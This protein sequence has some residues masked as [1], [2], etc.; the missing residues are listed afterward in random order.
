[1]P[2][3][4]TPTEQQPFERR[5]VLDAPRRRVGGTFKGLTE[6]PRYQSLPWEKKKIALQRFSENNPSPLSAPLT[7]I[8]R[9]EH[10]SEDGTPPSREFHSKLLVARKDWLKRATEGNEGSGREADF[11]YNRALRIAQEDYQN[12]LDERQRHINMALQFESANE[13]TKLSPGNVFKDIVGAFNPFDN[14]EK[15]ATEFTNAINEQKNI[16]DQ[17]GKEGFDDAAF[18]QLRADAKLAAGNT[19]GAPAAVDSFGSV[20]VNDG[21]VVRDIESVRQAIKDLNAPELEK[22]RAL[23]TLD[24]RQENL[25]ETTFNAIAFY[26]GLTWDEGEG[27]ER[28]NPRLRPVSTLGE[29][30]RRFFSEVGRRAGLDGTEAEQALKGSFEARDAAGLFGYNWTREQKLEAVK[31]LVE[32]RDGDLDR[33]IIGAGQGLTGDIFNM[34]ATP[35]EIAGSDLAA[36]LTG[37]RKGIEDSARFADRLVDIST[38]EQYTELASRIIPQVL[39][40]R[41]VGNLGGLGAARAGASAATQARVATVFAT[42]YGGYQS[43]TFNARDVLDNGGTT[44][45]A[46]G[47]GI[48]GFGT[49]FLLANGFSAIGAGG[50]EQFRSK[51]AAASSVAK[52]QLR[53][54]LFNITKQGLGEG[55]EE[56]VDEF[57][58]G[59]VTQDYTGAT[60]DQ[61]AENAFKAGVIGFGIGGVFGGIAPTQPTVDAESTSAE[62]EAAADAAAAELSGK[63]QVEKERVAARIVELRKK[64]EGGETIEQEDG[65]VIETGL[66]EEETAELE[67][68]EQR[69]ADD[70]FGPDTETETATPP[71]DEE[72]APT[73]ETPPVTEE[74]PPIDEEAPPVEE[75]A[76]PV[77]EQ[78]PTEAPSRSPRS[79]KPRAKQ[80]VTVPTETA[81][82]IN[83]QI[84]AG[85]EVSIAGQRGVL[86]EDEGRLA[87]KTPEGTIIE[88]SDSQLA[89]ATLQPTSF[90]LNSNGTVTVNGRGN[91][92][93]KSSQI[94]E[95]GNLESVTVTRP[96]GEEIVLTGDQALA[97][98]MEARKAAKPET[99][100]EV[101]RTPDDAPPATQTLS[102]AVYRGLDGAVSVAERVL[103]G[104]AGVRSPELVNARNTVAARIAEV[105]ATLRNGNFDNGQDVLGKL[106][107]LHDALD[108]EVQAR[109]RAGKQRLYERVFN[110]RKQA[111][112]PAESTEAPTVSVKLTK[113]QSELL[114]RS[115]KVENLTLTLE[116]AQELVADLLNAVPEIQNGNRVRSLENKAAEIEAK[117]EE[118]TPTEGD[119]TTEERVETLE[120]VMEDEN[121]EMTEEE[122]DAAVEDY[123]EAALEEGAIEENPTGKIEK[124]PVRE[125]VLVELRADLDTARADNE[126]LIEEAKRGN[127]YGKSG[128]PKKFFT[129]E[130]TQDL[131]EELGDWIGQKEDAALNYS[132]KPSVDPAVEDAR[133]SEI[134]VAQELLGA[135]ETYLNETATEE[136]A[137]GDSTSS[138]SG[139][140]YGGLFFLDPNFIVPTVKGIFKGA[141]TFLQ[142]SH[143]MLK[144]FG[145]ITKDAL[146][147]FWNSLRKKGDLDS[148]TSLPEET[149]EDIDPATVFDEE[150]A[151]LDEEMDTMLDE[152]SPSPS[153]S[154]SRIRLPRLLPRWLIDRLAAPKSG[155]QN[156]FIPGL[157]RAIQYL[158][159]GITKQIH[160]DIVGEFF[161][162]AVKGWLYGKE[163]AKR[164]GLF[165]ARQFTDL[166]ATELAVDGDGNM[167]AVR[168]KT[169]QESLR[170]SDVIENVMA[171]GRQNY[172]VSD[173]FLRMVADWKNVRDRILKDANDEGIPLRF[174]MDEDGNLDNS[175][176]LNN[177]FF[178]R[179]R[180]TRADDGQSSTGPNSPRPRSKVRSFVNKRRFETEQEGVET[181][182]YIYAET[183]A[184]RIESFVADVYGRIEDNR[185]ATHPDI[186]KASGK[187]TFIVDQDTGKKVKIRPLGTGNLELAGKTYQFKNDR[188][189]KL[190][191][192]I[193]GQ[194]LNPD[195]PL[196]KTTAIFQGVRALKFTFDFSAAAIQLAYLWGYSPLRAAKAVGLALAETFGNRSYMRNYNRNNRDLIAERVAL[197]GLYS[198]AIADVEFLNDTDNT[199]SAL[200][201]LVSTALSPFTNFHTLATEV[202]SNELYAAM[203]YQAV[204]KKTGKLDP[205]KAEKIVKFTDRAV[206]RESLSRNGLRA[207]SRSLLSMGSSAPGM[208]GAFIN[209]M[210]DVLSKDKFTRNQALKAHSRFIVGMSMLFLSKAMASMMMDDEDD[211][212]TEEKFYDALSRLNPKSRDF[213]TTEVPIGGG[214]RTRFSEGGFFK[215]ATQLVARV[216]TDPSNADQ[217][218]GQFLKSKKSP[219]IGTALEILTGEDYFGNEITTLEALSDA[220]VP[221]TLNQLAKDYRGPV[222]DIVAKTLN[223]VPGVS[224]KGQSTTALLAEKP[225]L[226]QTLE[227][228]IFNS[229][230]LSAY[231]ESAR[232]KFNRDIDR[233]S[234]RKFDGAKYRELDF[235]QKA[236]VVREAQE[237]G[238]IKPQYKT[239]NSYGEFIVGKLDRN[240]DDPGLRKALVSRG[241][242]QKFAAIPRYSVE[243]GNVTVHIDSQD[244]KEMYRAYLKRMED[245]AKS[246]ESENLD[247]DEFMFE[248][249]LAW[250]EQLRS[251]GY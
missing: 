249:E 62:V 85:R 73:Q 238:L 107:D 59:L 114:N 78:Q 160:N 123:T 134:E 32:A 8:Q 111:P 199:K 4:P 224:L 159:L 95:N 71:A 243:A 190:N 218:I 215:T 58:N 192:I 129:E 188:I 221:I 70:D 236:Q 240:L 181:G 49:T 13:I 66:T 29:T 157:G 212:S 139:V 79:S 28:K 84:K 162:R 26:G 115:G 109:R 169:G 167:T 248:S 247:S 43:A 135:Y 130:P 1:M 21:A 25:V 148:E 98:A 242:Y 104:P 217:Y 177:F 228:M 196:A 172:E 99:R 171:F 250:E 82:R 197:G 38:S 204:D 45:E 100:R 187:S 119:V 33:G 72:T 47:A 194:V 92:S 22:D 17:L 65:T 149:V 127:T 220:Y 183:P 234:A 9:L 74:V 225:H 184:Q 16:I 231:T 210:S 55:V 185:L 86:I 239:T 69:L 230:G 44:G 105:R 52:S 39:I 90:K 117:I 133:Q 156:T 237:T 2:L 51:A 122:E 14:E 50:V 5:A 174:L 251:N 108:G 56:F 116:E 233:L 76:P 61:L 223:L 195:E 93:Y 18:E 81:P 203:R 155:S 19:G 227:Q 24:L 54:R 145:A 153:R 11:N 205:V 186:V 182:N 20:V 179:G 88:L 209:I 178:P 101:P 244:H 23:R 6:D 118:A 170:P 202:A 245:F 173:N 229:V 208:Y 64:S 143:R 198:Q 97:V 31:E 124:P 63:R 140:L 35:L 166:Y 68:L 128:I 89:S 201:Q 36:D 154:S 15:K 146:R 91:F 67:A 42:G 113:M 57:I 189:I 126:Q 10:F 175:K 214:R 137:G 30:F 176:I 164:R 131:V 83:P 232:G 180:V 121:T 106:L 147:G 87:L 138:Q 235:D 158:S 144:Q 112:K 216:M 206:G 219:G 41:K 37:F 136:D 141:K 246:P 193:E 132:E 77:E 53:Q 200:R 46:L 3:P 75:E 226:G 165:V 163:M 142:F 222:I 110:G 152:N 125:A 150:Q 27:F 207:S 102:P 241:I 213:M 7:E 40:T 60:A 12:A 80:R 161:E 151:A 94:D 168:G 120:E 96:S 191:S 34:V 211:R 48:I 103:D